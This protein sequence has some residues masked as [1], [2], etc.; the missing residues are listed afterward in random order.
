MVRRV[1]SS[2]L[3]AWKQL[4]RVFEPWVLSRLQWML[5][6]PLP[7]TRTDS[8]VREN[9]RLSG[10][11]TSE[12]VE[13]AVLQRYLCNGEPARQRGLQSGSPTMTCDLACDEIAEHIRAASGAAERADLSPRG[14]GESG[15]KSQDGSK[16]VKTAKP[17]AC[18]CCVTSSHGK[19]EYK[20]LSPAVKQRFAQRGRANRHASEEVNSE[21]DERQL[22]RGTSMARAAH[23]LDACFPHAGDDDPDEYLLP[24]PV[25]EKTD[26]DSTNQMRRECSR[27]SGPVSVQT[28]CSNRAIRGGPSWFQVPQHEWWRPGSRRKAWSKVRGRIGYC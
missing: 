27:T 16:G 18:F 14:N 26:D 15:K 24:L 10:D 28:S 21:S 3:E 8:S 6:A 25:I 22:L 7:S 12:N 17:K 20:N 4:R 9:Q 5:Q 23:K 2:G 1:F 19:S 11:R 13:L